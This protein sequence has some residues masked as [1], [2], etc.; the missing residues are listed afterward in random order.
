MRR[1]KR[2]QEK[3]KKRNAKKK[4]NERGNNNKIKYQKF[5]KRQEGE[6]NTGQKNM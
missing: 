4:V 2:K 1:I 5:Q 3:W 6:E